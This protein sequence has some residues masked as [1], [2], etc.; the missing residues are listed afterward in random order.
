VPLR[1]ALLDRPAGPLEAGRV[2]P[3]SASR[4]EALSVR[5][6]VSIRVPLR[7]ALLDRPA[8]PLRG[9]LL[10]RHQTLK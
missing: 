9:A 6:Q 5:R 2:A 3:P 10:D 1:G 4:I 7:G 8:G